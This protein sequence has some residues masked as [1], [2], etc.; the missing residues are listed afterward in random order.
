MHSSAPSFQGR[1]A[2]QARFLKRLEASST[3]MILS[4]V[5]LAIPTAGRADP[6]EEIR[7]GILG[8]RASAYFYMR[9]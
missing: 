5:L 7:I 1:R 2:F 8:E 9:T 6:P 3:L 4:L